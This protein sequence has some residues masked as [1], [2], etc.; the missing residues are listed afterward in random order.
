MRAGII[1][2]GLGGL[3]AAVSLAR[4][5]SEVVIFEKLP[6]AGGRFTNIERSGYQLSTGALHMIPHGEKGPL[7]RMLRTLGISVQIKTSKPEGLFR[8][9]G[10]DYLFDE[11]PELFSMKEKLKL[12]AALASLKL[13]RGGKESLR[14]WLEKRINS[15][16]LLQIADSFC[17]W[18]LSV[19]SSKVSSGETAAITKNVNKFGG[20]GVPLGGCGGVT[21]ALVSELERL[22][23]KILYG[24]EVEKI[25]IENGRAAN[26]ATKEDSYDF[27][28]IISNAGP[29]ATIKLCGEENFPASY[30]REIKN[31]E[32]AAGIK[33]LATCEKA[34]L[35]HS[36]VLFTPQAQRIDGLNEVTNADPSLAPKGRHLLMSHQALDASQNAAKEVKLGIED[37]HAIFPDF[38][39]H[40][41]VLAV[42]VYKSGWPVNRA[43]SGVRISPESPIKNLYHVGDAV[44]PKGWMES[45]GVAAGVEL[46]LGHLQ[47]RKRILLH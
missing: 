27:D 1:G 5:G 32:E 42:H 24:M 36:G 34:M 2:S 9:N 23:G 4:R 40:C 10:K 16:L 19:D 37:L 25:E 41:K 6:Y 3:L 29:K 13:D 22:G 44:K 45:E 14:E 47:K 46:L 8:I 31:I 26:I 33:I 38:D 20:P 18:A 39:R 35:G 17:G 15:K 21:K 43:V 7:A 11:L 30:V 12:T 28:M